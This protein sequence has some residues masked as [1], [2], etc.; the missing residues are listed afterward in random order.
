MHNRFLIAKESDLLNT[1][2]LT[3]RSS[4]ES[5]AVAMP[6]LLFTYEDVGL[7]RDEYFISLKERIK[8]FILKWLAEIKMSTSRQ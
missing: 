5:L 3:F 6:F 2:F 8:Q 7:L 1:F 4:S